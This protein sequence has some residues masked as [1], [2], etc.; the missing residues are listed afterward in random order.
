MQQRQL[1]SFFNLS[2]VLKAV[3]SVCG[4]R[5]GFQ[6]SLFRVE[7]TQKPSVTQTC[8]GRFDQNIWQQTPFMR[9]WGRDRVGQ[10][11]GERNEKKCKGFLPLLSQETQP[12]TRRP[13]H[14]AFVLKSRDFIFAAEKTGLPRL[15]NLCFPASFCWKLILEGVSAALAASFWWPASPRLSPG[16]SVLLDHTHAWWVWERAAGGHGG[17][18]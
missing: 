5:A 18:S 14:D 3:P 12:W 7:F 16:E 8:L 17:P 2:H 1:S 4:D 6:K 15:G 9:C 13:S 11:K 10:I